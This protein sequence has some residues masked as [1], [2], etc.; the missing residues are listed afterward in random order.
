MKRFLLLRPITILVLFF[1]C[2]NFLAAKE[3]VVCSVSN[4][5]ITFD[6]SSCNGELIDFS[7]TFDAT[8]FGANGF[9]LTGGGITFGYSIGGPYTNSII[10]FCNGTD[11]WTIF[12]NDNPSC[13][14]TVQ[15][16][17]ICCPSNYEISTVEVSCDDDI[18]E[19]AF[20]YICNEGSCANYWPT[21][22]YN[23]EIYEYS[24]H[25]G[26]TFYTSIP[27]PQGPT[28]NFE[29]CTSVPSN[30][31]C[32]SFT[33]LNPCFM[34]ISN[35][36]LYLHNAY[37]DG[38][39]YFLPFS[40]EI[41]DFENNPITV[42]LNGVITQ[43]FTFM[44]ELI[45]E[46][47]ANC[48]GDI[49]IHF[50]NPDN[51]YYEFFRT[52]PPPCCPCNIE[53][54]IS[55]SQCSNGAFDM[56]I[57]FDF[58]E[59]SCGFYPFSIVLDSV[60]QE[61]ESFYSN[62]LYT[63][64]SIQ[65]TDSIYTFQICDNVPSLPECFT[66]S[67]PNPCF[68]VQSD[69]CTILDFNMMPDS[70]VCF[71]DSLRIPFQFSTSSTGHFAYI[72]HSSLGSNDTITN[73]SADLI[74]IAAP[75]DSLVI[76]TLT[77]ISNPNCAFAD[78]IPFLCCPC[79]F[80]ASI[81][82]SDCVN[83]S[84]MAHI[85]ID[86]TWGSCAHD[87]LFLVFGSRIYP[88]P[89][90]QQD[91]SITINSTMDSIHLSICN[92]G[93]DSV[94]RNF[95]LLNPCF[96]TSMPCSVSNLVITDT[97][98]C[99]M[100]SY[101]N[102]SFNFSG[103]N[104]GNVA[105][106]LTTTSGIVE[107]FDLGEPQVI[108]LPADCVPHTMTI[109]DSEDSTCYTSVSIPNLCCPCQ[110]NINITQ[111]SC[112]S[113]SIFAHV[114]IDNISGSCIFHQWQI[115][116]NGLDFQASDVDSSFIIGPITSTDSLLQYTVCG[117]DVIE[118]YCVDLTLPNP[119][120][121]EPN[122]CSIQSMNVVVDSDNCQNDY[123]NCHVQIQAENFGSDG[124]Y[125]SS[126]N[127]QEWYFDVYQE[128]IDIALLGD[129]VQDYVL[130]IH[131]AREASC[132]QSVDLGVLCCA[133]NIDITDSY[134]DCVNAA[135]NAE[136]SYNSTGNA[137]GFTN[138]LSS[139][140]GVNII[141]MHNDSLIIV[142]NINGFP[143]SLLEFTICFIYPNTENC[144]NFNIVNPCFISVGTDDTDSYN[145]NVKI[146]N[147]YLSLE[148]YSNE[149]IFVGI[150]D[151]L[152]K[153]ALPKFSVLRE[154]KIDIPTVAWPLGKYFLIYQIKDHIYQKSFVIIK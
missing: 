118:P 40:M 71:A 138:I 10:A 77:D 47:P 82:T 12:D 52:I 117:F 54:N 62:G 95:T 97:G 19:I 2:L 27:E 32:Q 109:T 65:S 114:T 123:L 38:S 88:L 113:G 102:V 122:I 58:N 136:F 128:N 63:I 67:V 83:G 46:I 64:P 98:V 72:L 100:D 134:S 148:N 106:I 125:L 34:A 143:D 9:T 1:G 5:Q 73:Q 21:I 48:D 60:S 37:C 90:N 126:I 44:D 79:G 51:Y 36:D 55:T 8:D 61:F 24:A 110:A 76:F 13:S 94:C 41:Y 4:L 45:L 149:D 69:S 137:C 84:F 86:S 132:A 133:C 25:F 80:D 53:S 130:T 33:L 28:I 116:V 26:S 14:T 150:Y 107:T 39:T 101:R 153:M 31:E 29:I 145:F 68:S 70:S 30:N 89:P 112:S 18:V 105:Y 92:L 23:G 66:Y 135:F 152:G 115:S 7:F 81:T 127:G 141:N 50:Y 96:P 154:E 57:D 22:H 15:V 147:G 119:C 140:N 151:V 144:F 124:F 43:T 142:Q 35:I 56:F 59:G 74:T 108:N 87:T 85:S 3:N 20:N 99:D 129:C 91:T 146:Q 139:V 131:D 49:I 42:D 104:F 16:S 75:C 103:I 93:L 120:Y 17:P 121:F 6:Q 78:T 111:D 11:D